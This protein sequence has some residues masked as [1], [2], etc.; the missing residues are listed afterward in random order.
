MST[1]LVLPTDTVQDIIRIQGVEIIRLRTELES[2]LASID[3]RSFFLA[4]MFLTWFTYRLRKLRLKTN[5]EQH[6][7]KFVDL[8]DSQHLRQ[9]APRQ[10]PRLLVKNRLVKML[11]RT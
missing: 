2:V 9:K 7:P 5:L 4:N 1:T 8:E 11:L 6:M 10:A 3:T